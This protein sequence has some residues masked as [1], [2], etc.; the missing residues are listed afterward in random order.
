MEAH[1]GATAAALRLQR[2]VRAAVGRVYGDESLRAARCTLL[3]A[4]QLLRA[5]AAAAAAAAEADAGRTAAAARAEESVAAMAEE[6]AAALRDVLRVQRARAALLRR[7]CGRTAEALVDDQTVAAVEVSEGALSALSDLA[8]ERREWADA[9]RQLSELLALQLANGAPPASRIFTL[10]KLVALTRGRND[11]DHRSL[12]ERLIELLDVHAT[13]READDAVDELVGA[14]RRAGAYGEAVAL[15][16]ARDAKK[17]EDLAHP[18]R[19]RW[20]RAVGRYGSP[21]EAAAARFQSG[22]RGFLDRRR[23]VRR[24][25]SARLLQERW[26]LS[27]T[28]ERILRVR[29]RAPREPRERDGLIYFIV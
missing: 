19:A 11:A 5:R 18:I 28:K 9:E 6:A 2:S 17:A 24:D 13:E 21:E 27:R 25:A 23:Q 3:L 22:A 10:S 29:C 12:L 16:K 8:A 26:K 20:R 14:L 4:Q 15:V 1:P 7:P